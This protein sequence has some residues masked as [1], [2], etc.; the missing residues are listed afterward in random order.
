MNTIRT[1]EPAAPTTA[2]FAWEGLIIRRAGFLD[3]DILAALITQLGYPTSADAILG[4]LRSLLSRP[5]DHLVAVADWKGR[6]AGVIV[7]TFSLHLELDG[8]YGF[9]TAL[10]VDDSQRGKGIGAALLTFAETWLHSRGASVC[11][12]NS[13]VRRLDAHRFYEREGYRRT[14][15]RFEKKWL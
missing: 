9:I 12:V 6:V 2:P 5:Q 4:R 15:H 3:T 14:G 7:A 13:H 8:T 1:T 11:I 10:S